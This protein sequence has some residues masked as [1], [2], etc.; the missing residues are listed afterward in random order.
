MHIKLLVIY[1]KTF[2]IIK[3]DAKE[4]SGIVDKIFY[5]ILRFD[6]YIYIF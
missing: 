5:L 4:S 1:K 6:E 2:L 3:S